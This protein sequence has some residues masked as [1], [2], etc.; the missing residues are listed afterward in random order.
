MTK[1][2]INEIKIFKINAAN[3]L[4]LRLTFG[5]KCKRKESEFK[6]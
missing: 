5:K 2:L 3:I 6:Y 1:I 4:K